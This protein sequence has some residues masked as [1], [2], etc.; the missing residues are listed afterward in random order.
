MYLK[1]IF[2]ALIVIVAAATMNANVN[3]QSSDASVAPKET[4][5]AAVPKDILGTWEVTTTFPD[6]F[7]SKSLLTFA[8]GATASTGS[9]FSTSDIDFTAPIPCANQQGVWSNSDGLNFDLT[10][11]GFCYNAQDFSPFGTLKIRGR[12]TLGSLGKGFT[13]KVFVVLMKYDGTVD[14]SSDATVRAVRMAVE[15]LP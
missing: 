10:F 5:S 13:G 12:I 6:G 14:F 3:A 4:P 15:P 11:K 1:R 7:R 8:P 2:A 9:L